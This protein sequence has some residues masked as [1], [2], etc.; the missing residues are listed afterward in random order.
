MKDLEIRSGEGG[1]DGKM[2][3]SRAGADLE[4][5]TAA[6]LPSKRKPLILLV[7]DSPA[8]AQAIGTVLRTLDV[9]CIVAGNGYQGH[10]LFLE[11]QDEIDLV[12]LDMN[13]PVMD[14]EHTLKALREIDPEVKVLIATS[15]PKEEV[16][17]RCAEQ[18]QEVPHYLRK[19]DAIGNVVETLLTVL[20]E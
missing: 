2:A 13:M 19:T 8:I 12:M 9:D 15:A 5:T 18:G 4:N 1:S 16:M 10:Q 20:E 6:A 17:Q 14:G 11:H 7:D 3:P